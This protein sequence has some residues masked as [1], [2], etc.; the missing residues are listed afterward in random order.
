MGNTRTNSL[1]MLRNVYEPMMRRI[2][3]MHALLL[4]KIPIKTRVTQGKNF[5][6]DLEISY[7]SGPSHG[8]GLLVP[9]AS[10][11]EYQNATFEFGG[12]TDQFGIDQQ[13]LED[14]LNGG[15]A[16]SAIKNQTK[17]AALRMRRAAAIH[18]Y[19]DGSGLLAN[20]ATATSA[21]SFT[22]D[23][24]QYGHKGILVDIL[25]K[26]SG[27]PNGVGGTGLK[28]SLNPTTNTWTITSGAILNFS[29]LNTDAS[30]YGVYK[31]NSYPTAT[32]KP[33]FGLA[34]ALGS[35]NPP[36]AA[37]FYGGLDRSTDANEPWRGNVK[38][39]GG[40][41]RE[42]TFELIQ[43]GL[44]EVASRGNEE[45][46]GVDLI[47]CHNSRWN[48]LASVLN[49]QRRYTGEKAL[50]L[51]W[52]EAI[53]FAGITAPIVKDPL[54]PLTKAFG[55]NTKSVSIEQSHPPQFQDEHGSMLIPNSDSVGYH[56]RFYWR[57]QLCTSN[58]ANGVI[59][60]DLAGLV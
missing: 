15:A 45:L 59:W 11:P 54:C 14:S 31:H 42:L 60:E 57:W 56:A 9:P 25:L 28:C 16:E 19:G 30:L 55:I 41:Q 50:L 21:T 32:N 26:S 17:A 46:G 5:I 4:Q 12:S 1:A 29:Q 7:G 24:S 48:A 3:P 13:L 37:G 49:T 47:V 53:Q 51:G 33:S 44:D 2:M 6:Y 39:N 23:N 27:S 43:E 52:A 22:V 10:E 38:S 35:T 34:A 40:V 20:V 58:P 36:T 8:S 18:L